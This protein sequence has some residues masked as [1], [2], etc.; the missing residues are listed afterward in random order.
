MCL[1]FLC[2]RYP[3]YFILDIQNMVFHNKILQTRSDLRS[4]HPLQVIL[5]NIPEDFV[6]TLRNPEDG[7][8]YLRAGVICS[9][10][11]WALGTKMGLSLR[12]IHGTVPDY[13][14]KMHFS[15]QRFPHPYFYSHPNSLRYEQ[16]F[17]HVADR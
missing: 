1:Q 6:I 9:S 3:Q 10:M 7:T 16:I 13:K 17:R 4:T 5:N 2:A 12:E 8:Y 11:G 15:M 14:E